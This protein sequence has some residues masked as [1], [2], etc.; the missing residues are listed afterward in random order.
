MLQS[1]AASLTNL[2]Q[3]SFKL[4]HSQALFAGNYPVVDMMR[5]SSEETMAPVNTTSQ[6]KMWLLALVS[7]LQR[8]SDSVPFWWSI[9]LASAGILAVFARHSMN[10]DG[11]SYLDLASE[12][13]HSGPSALLNGYW[14]PGYP[15]L[16]SLALA[17]FRPSPGQEFPL[18]HFVNFFI[19][20]LTLLA[21]HFFL[22][23]WLLSH[24]DDAMG[25]QEKKYFVPFAYS[26]FLWFTLEY[27]GVGVVTPDLCV[28]AIVFLAAGITCRLS[29]PGSSWKRYAAL[30]VILGL[31]YYAKSAMFP[32]G[33]VFLVVLLLY[34]PSGRRTRPK[35]LFSLTVFLLMAAPLVTM[36]SARL[37]R[38]S[39]GDAGR[40]N[41]AWY[42]NGLPRIDLDAKHTGWVA[43]SPDIYGSPEHPPRKLIEKPLVL[44]FDTPIKG[45]SPLWYDPSYWNAGARVRFNLRQQIV[46][47]KNTFFD[48]K[49]MFS[50]TAA[51]FSGAVVLCILIV[52]DK[53]FS[54]LPL[55]E[56]WL[57]IWPLAAMLMY[58]FVHVESR[59][60]GGFLVLL[61][62]WIYGALMFRLP[63]RVAAAVCATVAGTLMIVLVVELAIASARS[64]RDLVQSTPPDYQKIAVALGNLGLRS[65]DR[66]AVVG[67]QDIFVPYYARYARL[68]VVAEI[69]SKDEFWNLSTSELQSVADDL[70]RIGVKAI[71]VTSGAEHGELLNKDRPEFS[72]LPNW[73]EVKVSDAVRC[74]VLLLSEKP[75]AKTPGN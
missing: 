14:S 24:A 70:T 57:V 73:R 21:F 27:I 54:N 44:E 30:G 2:G 20:G 22:R 37:G 62:L 9:C 65:E 35:L 40:L 58:A 3:R 6:P 43:G 31:G 38:L 33:L 67:F 46:A 5:S 45:T 64:V 23:Q 34:S 61:W 48:Y 52:F 53:R 68:R 56:S 26:T 72:V 66:L 74:N 15:A 7:F 51:F 75:L 11:L 17:L 69:N 36:L 41:Y 60:V 29:L 63:R 28:A 10:S 42:V 32:L 71:V 1:A 47:L 55:R 50:Q 13:L 16:L 12:A 19:F 39:I 59:F 4:N 8:A 49:D 25:E 18:V